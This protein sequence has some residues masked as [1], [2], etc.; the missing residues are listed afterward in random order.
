MK[1]LIE[2]YLKQTPR[3]QILEETGLTITEYYN[4][5][6]ELGIARKTRAGRLL[7]IGYDII[8]DELSYIVGVLY[9][10]GYIIQ[11]YGG[12]G[13]ESI[14]KEFADEF[15]R[16][17]VKQFGLNLNKYETKKKPL[18]DWRNGKTYI[19]KN[20]FIVRMLSVKIRDYLTEIQNFEFINKLNY[21]QKIIFLRGLWDSEGSVGSYKFRRGVINS[22][23]FYHKTEKLC[24][25]YRDLVKETCGFEPFV[26]KRSGS[27]DMYSSYFYK[28]EYIRQFYDIVNPTIQRKRDKFES[29]LS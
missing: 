16:C 14:D 10:D 11:A 18:L 9:G 23:S 2:L 13:L 3:K 24:N 7:K 21:E 25:V 12:V 6:H 5:I 1:K 29:I 26:K 28:K 15:G 20:T 27:Y 8:T 17:L 22:V 4:K 19:R